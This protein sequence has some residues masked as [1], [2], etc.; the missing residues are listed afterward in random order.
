MKQLR[1]GFSGKMKSGKSTLIDET[2]LYLK[3][4]NKTCVSLG[5]GE[6]INQMCLHGIG[7][8]SREAMQW[9]GQFI[10][11]GVN[12]QFGHEDFWPNYAI[13]MMESINNNMEVDV[14]LMDSIRF[15]NELYIFR[16]HGFEIIRLA[17]SKE[18]QKNRENL[19]NKG[20]ANIDHVT[21]LGLDELDEVVRNQNATTFPYISFIE[22]D[23]ISPIDI[24]SNHVKPVIDEH[25]GWLGK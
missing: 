23:N 19:K 8:N 13:H 1:L 10:R 12:K 22:T 6:F 2:K 20:M 3:H 15:K 18:M 5:I 17:V 4:K 11:D 16:H 25:F 7:D 9:F 21:E 14:I 24:F